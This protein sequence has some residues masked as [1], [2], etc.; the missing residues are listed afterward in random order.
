MEDKKPIIFLGFEH[1]EEAKQFLA[2]GSGEQCFEKSLAL[3][4][5]KFA[6]ACLS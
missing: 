2:L 3:I 1:K 4:N 6:F 5:R